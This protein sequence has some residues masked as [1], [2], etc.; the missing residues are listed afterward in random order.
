[1]VDWDRARHARGSRGVNPWCMQAGTK[2]RCCIAGGSA[3]VASW[4][5]RSLPPCCLGHA[6]GIPVGWRPRL[7]AACHVPRPPRIPPPCGVP[8]LGSPAAGLARLGDYPT[9]AKRWITQDPVPGPGLWEHVHTNAGL[10]VQAEPGGPPSHCQPLHT[11]HLHHAALAAPSPQPRMCRGVLRSWP[12][13]DC[14]T[15]S[16]FTDSL[17]ARKHVRVCM[18]VRMC[19]RVGLGVDAATNRP[20]RLPPSR[21]WVVA[22]LSGPVPRVQ[23]V[24]CEARGERYVPAAA[25]PDSTQNAPALGLLCGSRAAYPMAEGSIY[26]CSCN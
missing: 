22:G 2:G 17:H 25:P 5:P 26:S 11:T 3:R 21:K 24:P 1:M 18:C 4:L 12:P 6:A 8:P 13:A 19:A 15:L 23:P 14:S 10:G 20:S 16:S 7:P 9:R